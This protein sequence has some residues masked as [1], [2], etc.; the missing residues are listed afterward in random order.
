[1]ATTILGMRLQ[2]DLI[3]SAVSQWARAKSFLDTANNEL[4]GEIHNG[5]GVALLKKAERNGNVEALVQA[6]DELSKALVIRSE[7]GRR[8]PWAMTLSN[9]GATHDAIGREKQD[10][11]ELCHATR[12]YKEALNL[13]SKRDHSLQWAMTANNVAYALMELGAISGKTRPLFLAL[14]YYRLALHGRRKHIAKIDW[15]STKYNCSLARLS[16][17]EMLPDKRAKLLCLARRDLVLALEVW[18]ETNSS[19]FVDLTQRA[20]DRC[21]QE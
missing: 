12:Y 14:G 5:F 6:K 3:E 2:N 4:R 11:K 19:F 10:P 17:A 8:G 7:I 13:I 16:L 1:M 15:A 9:L 20:L 18:Q 21:V